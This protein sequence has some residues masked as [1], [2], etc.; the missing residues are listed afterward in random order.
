M[1]ITWIHFDI[2]FAM[3]AP[4]NP[5]LGISKKLNKIEKIPCKKVDVDTCFTFLKKNNGSA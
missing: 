5:N 3:I 2:M 1:K 4:I